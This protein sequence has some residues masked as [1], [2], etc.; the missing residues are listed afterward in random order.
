MLAVVVEAA[1]SGLHVQPFFR[2]NQSSVTRHLRRATG[3]SETTKAHEWSLFFTAEDNAA[4][5][6]PTFACSRLNC[7]FTCMSQVQ[8]YRCGFECESDPAGVKRARSD[9]V[10]SMSPTRGQEMAYDDAA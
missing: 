1:S 6:G 7:N 5:S 4:S 8:G 10:D 3:R 9:S 2:W